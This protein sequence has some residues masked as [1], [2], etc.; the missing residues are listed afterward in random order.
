MRA[1]AIAK[2]YVPEEPMTLL[3][4]AQSAQLNEDAIAS[5]QAFE[6]MLEKPEMAELGLRGLFIEAKKA[7][8]AEAAKQFA[9]RALAAN[10]GLQWS[11]SALFDIQ[12]REGDWRGALNT[13][14]QAKHHRHLA[15]AEADRRR[16][17]LLTQLATELEETQ[18]GKAL[19]YAQEALGLSPSLV[20]A[21]AIAGR[22]L[23]SQ[24]NTARA[25]KLLTQAWHTSPHPEIAL[26]YAHARTG[27]SPRDRLARVKTLAGSGPASPGGRYRRCGGGH[28]GQGMGRGTRCPAAAPGE[29][30]CRAGLPFDGAHRGWPEPGSGARPRMARQGSA[31]RAGPGLGCARWRGFPGMAGGVA[32]IWRAWRVRMA[33]ASWNGRQRRQHGWPARARCSVRGSRTCFRW[34]GRLSAGRNGAGDHSSSEACRPETNL[35]R[36]EVQPAPTEV[37]DEK[38]EAEESRRSASFPGE[39]APA[40][41]IQIVPKA[42]IGTLKP[43]IRKPKIFVPGPAPDD[44]GPRLPDGDE[45]GTPLSRFR[46]PF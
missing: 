36:L 25:T 9:Q 6:R 44:P 23:A 40:P 20:P 31:R 29:R 41:A 24:G 37:G 22:I 27:D 26:I 46:R 35:A 11:S 45:P 39:P 8:Q 15:R 17:L 2:K 4:E 1:G 38:G 14:G 5:R 32:K 18:Q 3:L 43:E 34:P 7:G 10:P 42:G 21:A 16:A 19:A 13:L 33:N 12:C 28:R 30:A